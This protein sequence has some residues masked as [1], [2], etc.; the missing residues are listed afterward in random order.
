MSWIT[1]ALLG[2][3]WAAC[4]VVIGLSPPLS[5]TGR[6]SSSPFVGWVC[7]AFG[8]YV[9]ISGFRRAADPPRDV[10]TRTR[11]GSGREP[12][13]RTAWLLPVAWVGMGLAGVGGIWWGVAAHNVTIGAFG[14]LTA[15]FVLA[16]TPATLESVRSH[17][18]RR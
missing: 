16:A 15:S 6:G 11:H 1:Q 9:L 12:D 7:A 8:A 17:R 3:V 5:E 4:G 13:R 2:A 10:T 18:R 14:V